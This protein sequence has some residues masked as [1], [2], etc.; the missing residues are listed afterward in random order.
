MTGPSCEVAE[1]NPS[2]GRYSAD[3]E[4]C[5]A[6]AL[7]NGRELFDSLQI[8]KKSPE[9]KAALTKVFGEGN[10]DRGHEMVK[11]WNNRIKKHHRKGTP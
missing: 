1:K 6:R 8:G 5:K 3:C 9:Y 10:E 11:H 2:T 4:Q 7:A